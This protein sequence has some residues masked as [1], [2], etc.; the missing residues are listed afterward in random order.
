MAEFPALP[1]FTDAYLADTR[2]LTTIQHGAYFLMLVTA[3]RSADCSLP[4]DDVYLSRITGL[5]RRTWNSNKDA[6]L[7]FW[8]KNDQQKW[9]QGRL[10]DE[11]NYVEQKRNK[12]AAAGQASALKRKNRGSTPVQPKR[13]E[14]ATPT[15]TPTPTEERSSTHATPSAPPE[16]D[17][18][19]AKAYSVHP[20]HEQVRQYIVH[21][22]PHLK[23]RNA[24]A[25]SEWLGAGLDPG[26]HIFP[27]IE[28]VIARKGVDIGSFQFFTA[29]IMKT[30]DTLKE[31]AAQH[32]RMEAKYAALPQG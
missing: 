7:A 1:F 9:E 11:R 20:M 26:E 27:V 21:R 13:N 18:V 25:I 4:D 24:S 6:L 19:M 2:H 10:K 31:I 17:D 5:D 8:R 28:Q 16:R 3:W 30:A 15:P 32:K 12:N 22:L 23:S 29:E 14:T